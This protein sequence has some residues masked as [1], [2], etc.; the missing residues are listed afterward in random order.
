M[1]SNPCLPR[2]QISHSPTSKRARFLLAAIL[3]RKIQVSRIVFSLRARRQRQCQLQWKAT[4]INLLK[5]FQLCRSKA[6]L[7]RNELPRKIPMIGSCGASLATS[8]QSGYIGSCNKQLKY[9]N[10]VAVEH[11]AMP[12]CKGNRNY[13]LFHLSRQCQVKFA[14][15]SDQ[16]TGGTWPITLLSY[17]LF[18]TVR[19]TPA[20][21]GSCIHCGNFDKFQL[22][23]SG[24]SSPS[25]EAMPSQVCIRVSP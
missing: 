16:K 4:S 11:M 3:P 20:D 21:L 7:E 6:K 5:V 15:A 17:Y 13:H 1:E 22:C 10:S 14:Y 2:I 25:A 18:I 12:E 9:F 23:C 24:A 19:H 8:K